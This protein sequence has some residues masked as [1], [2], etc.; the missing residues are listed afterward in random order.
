M[1]QPGE[2]AGPLDDGADRGAVEANEQ[3]ALP[4]PRFDAVIDRIRA[5]TD[6][7]I[8]GDESRA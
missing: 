7:H 4:M 6:R 5:G 3:V 2:T 1:E 8:V